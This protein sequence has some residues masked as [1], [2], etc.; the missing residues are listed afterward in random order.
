MKNILRIST[1]LFLI[2]ASVL[3]AE[4]DYTLIYAK[5]GVEH[6]IVGVEDSKLYYFE[7]E[8]KEYLTHAGQLYIKT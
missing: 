2:A 5:D 1:S 7:N 6:R 4:S 8:E 3:H